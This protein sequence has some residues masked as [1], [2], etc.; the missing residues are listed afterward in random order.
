MPKTIKFL[1]NF[2][3]YETNPLKKNMT[4]FQFLKYNSLNIYT[5]PNLKAAYYGGTLNGNGNEH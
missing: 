1:N 2:S 5:D 3:K 4:T